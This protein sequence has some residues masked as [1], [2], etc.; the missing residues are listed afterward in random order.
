MF[1]YEKEQVR[2]LAYKYDLPSKSAKES[3][4][5]CFIERPMTTRKYLNNIFEPVE[6]KFIEKSTGKFLGK[7]NGFWQYTI[8][9]RKGIGIA[10]PEPLYVVNIDSKENIVYV[11]KQNYL[12]SNELII[13]DVIWSC[14]PEYNNF[15]ALVKVRYN[16]Q[17][18]KANVSIVGENVVNIKFKE[19]VSSI[20]PGQACVLYNLAEGFLLGGGFISI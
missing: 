7:H 16:M 20:T 11:D 5:I 9:Q 3:Q 18:V 2:E 10:A 13:N 14:L 19:P 8:G 12:F 4:D 17:P 1:D 15:E 6:G